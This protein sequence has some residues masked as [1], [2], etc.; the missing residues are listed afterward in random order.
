LL[1]FELKKQLAII[2]LAHVLYIRLKSLL[3]FWMWDISSLL[4]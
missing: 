2:E 1:C 4:G 3:I